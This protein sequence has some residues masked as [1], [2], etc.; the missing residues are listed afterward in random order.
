MSGPIDCPDMVRKFSMF[1]RSLFMEVLPGWFVRSKKGVFAVPTARK[2]GDR[3]VGTNTRT[4][5]SE[6]EKRPF[7]K[8]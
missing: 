2:T 4:S 3:S 1:F 7:H 8:L 5:R 6:N